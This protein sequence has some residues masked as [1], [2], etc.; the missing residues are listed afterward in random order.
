M[1]GTSARE[2][3]L[4]SARPGVLLLDLD[5]DDVARVLDDLGNKR[6]VP[7]PDL[8]HDPFQQ[9]H[10]TACHPIFP[11]NANTI[12]ERLEIGLNHTERSMDRPENE[13]NDEKVMRVPE[14]LELGPSGLL[15]GG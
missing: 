15:H 12:A 10:K 9:I 7:P 8:A 14:S 6:F 1:Q 4:A 2:N 13:E 11:E 5:L 3:Y